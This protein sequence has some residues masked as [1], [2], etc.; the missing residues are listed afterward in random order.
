MTGVARLP[1]VEVNLTS[2]LKYDAAIHITIFSV[3]ATI[4][5]I[6]P[7]LTDPPNGVV[8]VNPTPIEGDVATYSCNSGFT[9]VG[10]LERVCQSDRTWSRS[11]PVCQQIGK[12]KRIYINIQQ[13]NTCRSIVTIYHG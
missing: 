11:V 13:Y 5:A 6:C 12:N 2:R 8:V 3:S 1:N 9:L 7:P 10:N 4:P